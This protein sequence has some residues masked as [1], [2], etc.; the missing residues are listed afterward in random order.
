MPIDVSRMCTRM[1]IIRDA[2]V[3]QQRKKKSHPQN[4]LEHSSSISNGLKGLA[5]AFLWLLPRARTEAVMLHGKAMREKNKTTI[6]DMQWNANARPSPLAQRVLRNVYN[7]HKCIGCRKWWKNM[8]NKRLFILTNNNLFIFFIFF[9]FERKFIR[10]FVGQ[11]NTYCVP[12][13]LAL[14]AAVVVGELV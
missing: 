4:Q 8:A 5:F 9:F 2:N 1:R 10:N 13:T 7:R 6:V 3:E 14:V 12:F 11:M